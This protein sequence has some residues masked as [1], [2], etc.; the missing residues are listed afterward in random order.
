YYSFSWYDWLEPY[1]PLSTPMSA[2]GLDR[3]VVLGEFPSSG[4]QYHALPEVLDLMSSGRYAGA[5]AWS[6]WSGDGFGSWHDAGPAFARW[7]GA[8][9]RPG[10]ASVPVEPP[11]RIRT[12]TSV[13]GS[14]TVAC[15]SRRRSRSHR[16]NRLSPTSTCTRSAAPRPS[17]RRP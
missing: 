7:P 16:A 10:G 5:F 13:S 14:R 11:T 9:H 2:L 4:S 1:E 15:S 3:P 8:R 6:Y 12:A 17:R